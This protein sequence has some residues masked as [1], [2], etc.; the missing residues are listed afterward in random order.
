V[1]ELVEKIKGETFTFPG[2]RPEVYLNMKAVDDEFPGFTTPTDE[3]IARCQNEGIKIVLGDKPESGN[4]FVLP[5]TSDNIEMD[6]IISPYQLI[7]EN[8]TNEYLTELIRLAPKKEK[9]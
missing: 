5:V 9:L 8:V 3:I 4:V 7:A 6:G 1:L 2:I